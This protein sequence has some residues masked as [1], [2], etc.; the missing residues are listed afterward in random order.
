M[1][2]EV[3]REQIPEPALG[4]WP[5]PQATGATEAEAEAES[6]LIESEA[7]ST[8]RETEGTPKRAPELPRE[9]EAQAEPEIDLGPEAEADGCLNLREQWNPYQMSDLNNRIRE[10]SGWRKRRERIQ[11]SIILPQIWIWASHSSIA[12]HF[13][14]RLNSTL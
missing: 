5:E 8:D 3:E 10:R 4:N 9:S 13:G 2:Q 6:G 12:S 14:A 7:D 11:L 1:G